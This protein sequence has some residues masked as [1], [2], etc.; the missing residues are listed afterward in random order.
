M[1]K[2]CKPQFKGQNYEYTDIFPLIFHGCCSDNGVDLRQWNTRRSWDLHHGHQWLVAGT[3]A[4]CLVGGFP[5][6]LEPAATTVSIVSLALHGLFVG[7]APHLSHYVVGIDARCVCML[8]AETLFSYCPVDGSSSVSKENGTMLTLRWNGTLPFGPSHSASLD[9]QGM[10][11]ILRG[12]SHQ[13]GTDSQHRCPA[14]A[15]GMSLTKSS[16]SEWFAN[17]ESGVE[18]ASEQKT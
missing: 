15:P 16:F 14:T 12:I 17:L 5:Q 18:D 6:V 4:C 3:C 1:L 8:V 11:A 9:V 7:P 13:Y 10:T 2:I